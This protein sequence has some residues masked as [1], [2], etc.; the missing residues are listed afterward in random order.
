M[1]SHVV[2]D[3]HAPP[4]DAA[5]DDS[6]GS[7]CVS[8]SC[9]QDHGAGPAVNAA[10]SASER[11][12]CHVP[13][14]RRTQNCVRQKP[15]QIGYPSSSVAL[16][17][18]RVRRNGSRSLAGLTTHRGKHVSFASL[19]LILMTRVARPGRSGRG[20]SGS[21]RSGGWVTGTAVAGRGGAAAGGGSCVN[22]AA[23][24]ALLAE[25]R[26]LPLF[27]V[28]HTCAWAGHR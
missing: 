13:S 22:P 3:L 11:C 14:F 12:L 28:R 18:F 16:V 20:S 7:G 19:V 23:V 10:S 25:L 27:R 5:H 8:G 9:G 1:Q 26:S 24:E 6:S 17:P 15:K 21:T 2:A 4:P